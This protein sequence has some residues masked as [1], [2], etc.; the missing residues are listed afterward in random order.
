M[1]VMIMGMD[2]ASFAFWYCELCLICLE[3]ERDLLRGGEGRMC[4]G[5]SDLW[6]GSGLL[7]VAGGCGSFEA[8]P[9]LDAA[10]VFTLSRTVASG[11]LMNEVGGDFVIGGGSVM[12]GCSDAGCS[13]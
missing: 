7:V 1:F 6:V 5:E 3:G 13:S 11:R 12:V 4:G 9:E 2:G 10:V 8:R